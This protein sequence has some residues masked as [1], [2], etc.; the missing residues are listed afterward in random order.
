MT[1]GSSKRFAQT[2]A[3]IPGSTYCCCVT[4]ARDQAANA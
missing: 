4:S 2:A 1:N 3:L